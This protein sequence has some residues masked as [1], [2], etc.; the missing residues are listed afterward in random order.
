[1]Q[2]LKMRKTQDIIV[3]SG[4]FELL[5]TCSKYRPNN[6][7]YTAILYSYLNSWKSVCWT[8]QRAHAKL[9]HSP[10]FTDKFI[11]Y[12]SWILNLLFDV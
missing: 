2:I 5:S 6:S 3:D 9:S 1:M 12:S 8:G 11:D 4:C 10:S 7:K